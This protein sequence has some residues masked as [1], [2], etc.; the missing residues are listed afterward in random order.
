MDFIKQAFNVKH[1]FWRYL[2]GSLI[3]AIFA[4]IG[5]F[6]FAIAAMIKYVSNGGS[7]NA[8]DEQALMSVLEPN[9]NLFL[10]L[11]S[12]AFGF[13]GLIIVVK[14]LHNQT[15]KSVTTARKKI[16]F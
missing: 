11:L 4:V 8:M 10:L 13:L 9:L 12:F 3:I 2:V 1:E 7:I 6:P 5:Q 16:V 14:Y 15:M